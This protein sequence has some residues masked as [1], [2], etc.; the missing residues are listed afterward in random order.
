LRADCFDGS[1]WVG[2]IPFHMRHVRIGP[3]PAVPYLGVFVE[4]NV[5][6]Y[7]VDRFGHRGIW[8]WSLDVPRALPTAVA[9]TVFSLPY[10][11]GRSR[12]TVT[13]PAGEGQWHHYTHR[14]RWPRPAS[15]AAPAMAEVSYRMGERVPD[16]EVSDLDHFLSARWSLFTVRRGVLVR[17]DVEHPRWP[18]HRVTDVSLTSTLVEAAGLPSPSGTM[19]TLATP[20]VD[21]RLA[22]LKGC[23]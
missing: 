21:V 20:G 10:C 15:H 2:L 8:F 4:I 16:D 17:G 22:W 18:I 23:G 1:A 5:R 12:H 19:H 6:T 14:R 3:S 11:W 9:R 7:V 13:G